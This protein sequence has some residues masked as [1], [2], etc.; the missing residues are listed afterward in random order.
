MRHGQRRAWL[1][2]AFQPTRGRT[3]RPR[4]GGQPV[5][6]EAKLSGHDAEDGVSEGMIG[7]LRVPCVRQRR[8][9]FA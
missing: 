3:H 8:P 6:V 5:G 1:P 9:P 4:V 2:A 7:K